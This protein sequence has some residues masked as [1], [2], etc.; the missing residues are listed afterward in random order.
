MRGCFGGCTFCS[1][2][3][4]EGRI[5]QSR[6]EDSVLR[7]LAAVRDKTP[8]FTGVV[9][10]LGGPTANMYRQG[11]RSPAVEAACRRLSCVY[12]AICPNLDASHAALVSLYRRARQVRG[13]KKLTIGS[14]IRFDLA[15]HS[16]EYVEELARHHVGGYLKIAPEHTEPGPLGK[17]QKPGVG[18]FERF[19]A[20]FER[21]SRKAGKEQYLIPYFMAAHPGTTLAD[22]VAL[23]LW[24]KRNGFRPD[25]VQAFLPTPMALATAMYHSGH[26][27]LSRLRS[28]ASPTVVV[29]KGEAK[30]RLQKAFLRYHDP[31]NWPALRQALVRMGRPGLIGHGRDCLVAPEPR[32]HR[33]R[34]KTRR[35][36]KSGR[37]E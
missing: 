15:V 17:M 19:R 34:T 9:S 28:G 27:P 37:S 16:P 2:T 24:C 32:G 6:S 33:A 26:D 8:G 12:P 18:S 25:Q 20:M 29:S 31:Q 13:L 22:M 35:G 1:L 23:A 4:H 14:G 21:C 36:A 11:C 7:E 30:R 10:D 3:E 5:I